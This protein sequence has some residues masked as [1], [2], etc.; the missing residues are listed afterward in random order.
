MNAHLVRP[1][2][3]LSHTWPLSLASCPNEE[4]GLFDGSCPCAVVHGERFEVEIRCWRVTG[5]HSE[6]HVSGALPQQTLQRIADHIRDNNGWTNSTD[7]QIHL[8]LAP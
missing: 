6:I 4:D 7:W 8:Q 1:E 5:G 3:I 2:E